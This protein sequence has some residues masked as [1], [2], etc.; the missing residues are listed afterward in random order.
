MYLFAFGLRGVYRIHTMA[1]VA[2]TNL[3][4]VVGKLV[5]EQGLASPEDVQEVLSKSQKKG[6]AAEDPSQQSLSDMLVARSNA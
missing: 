5:V 2:E 1:T 3:D 6:P 4:S